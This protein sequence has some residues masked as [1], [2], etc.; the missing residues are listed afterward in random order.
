ML[1]TGS[2]RIGYLSRFFALILAVAVMGFY[3]VP[4]GALYAADSEQDL[5]DAAA[6]AQT[7]A[8]NAENELEA[9]TEHGGF[10]EEAQN[11]AA[12]SADLAKTAKDAM[13]DLVKA[14]NTAETAVTDLE[15]NDDD[16]KEAAL[17]ATA[18]TAVNTAKDKAK[19]A[20]DAI[21]DVYDNTETIINNANAAVD[22]ANNAI[23]YAEE[24]MDNAEKANDEYLK[25]LESL[26]GNIDA[27][28]FK[29]ISDAEEA[30][31]AAWNAF[32]TQ[33]NDALDKAAS[34]AENAKESSQIADKLFRDWQAEVAKLV[35]AIGSTAYNGNLVSEFKEL[36]DMRYQALMAA[37]QAR[38]Y[39]FE[40]VIAANELLDL[41]ADA[42]QSLEDLLAKYWEA[43]GKTL[44]AG[45]NGFEF[46]INELNK[47]ISQINSFIKVCDKYYLGGS[48]SQDG[49]TI[50]PDPL[51]GIQDSS[52]YDAVE[53]KYGKKHTS[54]NSGP[55]EIKPG[56]FLESINDNKNN[57]GSYWEISSNGSWVGTLKI[58]YKVSNLYYTIYM[59]INGNGGTIQFAHDGNGVVLDI[60]EMEYHWVDDFK[61]NPFTNPAVI[62]DIDELYNL[63]DYEWPQPEDDDEEEE[64]GGGPNG[65]G[66]TGGPNP[67][68]VITG[69]GDDD[70][71][72]VVLSG[73]T[74]GPG[75][76][77]MVMTTLT[78]LPPPLPLAAPALAPIVIDPPSTATIAD[79]LVPQAA[80]TTTEILP[81]RPPLANFAAW[82]LLNLILTVVTGLIMIALLVTYFAKRRED[83]E[84][85]G[86]EEKVKK[87]L[88]LRLITVAATVI[89]V[90][91]FVLTQNMT[92][93]MILIDQWTI[94]HV[95]ITAAAVLLAMASMKNYEDDE[96]LVENI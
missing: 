55:I 33:Q 95:I 24:A 59:E 9:I 30:V 51:V 19:D 61:S 11:A 91:L 50:T 79:D 94:L 26:D 62:D 7:A 93:P 17:L 90:I 16:S 73:G 25:L 29:A 39:A 43:Q 63:F 88:G 4:A 44:P 27:N 67:P 56:L 6:D 41:A 52:D 83:D 21:Q 12:D 2:T 85:Y 1:K 22:A 74:G 78:L 60:S 18:E 69:G 71:D 84:N 13:D 53:A 15:D 42:K 86:E 49:I 96:E 38:S 57:N 37:V 65:S 46:T 54:N 8:T 5:S 47:N 80:P 81:I 92:L 76:G 28:A 64:E 45:E 70:D 87:H 77:P 3:I 23:A 66:G 20:K 82:A 58:V 48:G 10:Q 72:T 14:V 34:I 68:P 89:A 36:Q 32:I 35:A 31:C 40:A 75:P